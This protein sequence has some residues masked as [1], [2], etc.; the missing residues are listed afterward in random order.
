MDSLVE[1][2]R[3]VEK[4]PLTDSKILIL[5]SS[6]LPFFPPPQLLPLSKPFLNEVGFLGS[7]HLAACSLSLFSQLAN[8]SQGA[9][10]GLPRAS[11]QNLAAAPLVQ[12]NGWNFLPCLPWVRRVWAR[13]GARP[14]A[15]PRAG[16]VC[17]HVPGQNLCQGMSQSWIHVWARPGA[18]PRACPRAGSMCGHVPG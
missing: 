5:P 3:S 4:I 1:M 8:Q 18:C 7:V 14:R 15:C 17:R 6:P 10:G 11:T 13:P 9:A 16:S 12:G 2:Q